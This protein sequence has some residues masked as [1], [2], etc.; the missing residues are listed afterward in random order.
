MLYP[1]EWQHQPIISIESDELCRRLGIEGGM[2]RM[3]DLFDND[4]RYRLEAMYK[5]TDRGLDRDILEVD[6]KVG[7]VL[8]LTSDELIVPRGDDVAPLSR[9][10]VAV[11]IA[12]NRLPLE[13]IFFMVHAVDGR[14]CFL[15]FVMKWRCRRLFVAA[16]YVSLS[17][18]ALNY[19][20]RWYVS[21]SI[22]LADGYETMQF[23][24]L[25]V[26]VLTCVIYRRNEFALPSGMLLPVLRTCGVARRVESDDNAAVAGAVVALAEPARDIGDDSLC[27][28]FVHDAQ[29]HCGSRYEA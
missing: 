12:Y 23:L 28:A 15:A 25:A 7:L 4:G 11:E 19:T 5:G 22:P 9:A 24:S 17:L 10:K 18:Q 16:L 6:E 20:M 1:E 21:G 14:D 13:R 3:T 29:R 26:L 8:M 27:A 2:A